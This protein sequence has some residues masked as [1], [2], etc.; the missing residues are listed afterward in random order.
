MLNPRTLL[1]ISLLSRYL[2]RRSRRLPAARS[3][4]LEQRLANLPQGPAPVSAPVQIAWSAH[5][6][7]SI[8]A[9]TD[10]DAAIGL[11]VVHG[12]LRLAQMEFMRRV[13][14]GRIAEIAGPVALDLDRALR[15]L[16][17]SRAVPDIEAQLPDATRTWLEGFCD[18]INHVIAGS[19]DLPPDLAILNVRPRPWEVQDVLSLSRLAA[20]DFSWRMWLRLLPHYQRADWAQVWKRLMRDDGIAMPDFTAEDGEENRA[21]DDLLGLHGRDG[22][23]SFVVSPRR[24]TSGASL[25]A[26][27]P[28]LTIGLPNLWLITGF[29]SPSYQVVGVMVPG[30]PV[31]ALGRNRR[32][33]WGGTS[34]HA[35]CSDLFSA[36]TLAESGIRIRHERIG[37]RWWRHTRVRIRETSVGPVISDAPGLKSVRRRT[38]AL[39]WVGHDVSDEIT[40]MLGVHR[41][42]NWDQF[43]TA[44]AGFA[45]PALNMTYADVDG[46]IGRCMA[47]RLPHRPHAAPADLIAGS[48]AL[49]HWKSRVGGAELPATLDPEEGYLASANDRPADP[50]LAVPVGFFFSPQ[51]RVQRLRRLLG[52]TNPLSTE[53]LARMQE[54]VFSEPALRLRDS[55]LR[56]CEAGTADAPRQSADTVKVLRLLAAWDGHYRADSTGA[57]AFELLVGNLIRQL[58]G[59]KPA[60]YASTLDPWTCLS[61]DLN[62]M[63]PQV[64]AQ[65]LERSAARAARGLRRYRV[66]GRAHR[67]RLAHTFAKLPGLGRGWRFV[68]AATGGCNETVMKMAYG[69][70]TRRHAVR[71]GAI[72]RHVSDLADP[73]ANRFVLLGGQ[74]GWIGSTTFLDQFALWRRGESLQVPLRPETALQTYPHLTELRPATPHPTTGSNPNA[75]AR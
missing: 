22:S 55:L 52:E 33:A 46:H 59:A 65:A 57:L 31:V 9:Q 49:A 72:A 4:S 8:V 21:L 56:L 12:H 67:L 53:A 18:G 36:H 41:A 42:E 25:I 44:L 14:K 71:F 34:L 75:V 1:G 16:N 23:N 28:H 29:S 73:D 62:E 20:V 51:D 24:S 3:I 43:R 38:L 64:L 27:D 6:V 68:D 30:V 48:D 74:D 7:P 47:A 66:W 17:V 15:I 37:A 45:V 19:P 11:G 39:R 35:A 61:E 2:R 32:I 54:D 13:A 26:S 70:S 40:A 5:H 60:L 10:R 69:L 63:Q 58:H 50:A